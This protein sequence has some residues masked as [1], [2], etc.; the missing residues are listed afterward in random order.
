MIKFDDGDELE[1]HVTNKDPQAVIL[2]KPPCY[3]DVHATN[4]VIAFWPGRKYFYRG[5]VVFKRD[6]GDSQCY[7]KH[8]YQVLFD[9]GDERTEDFNQIRIVPN[10]IYTDQ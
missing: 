3:M 10:L 9:D 2:D 4:G 5:H 1:L 7:Q 8:V 6:Y